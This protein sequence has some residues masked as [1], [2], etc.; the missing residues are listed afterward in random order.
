M[1]QIFGIDPQLPLTYVGI[2]EGAN[3]APS[4]LPYA[5]EIRA[6]ALVAGGRRFSEVLIHQ[7]SG[8]FLRQLEDLGFRDFGPTDVWVLLAL[9]QTIFDVQ[10][11][12]NHA[13]FL[14]R[15]PLPIAGSTR[16][17]SVLLIEGLDDSVMPNHA[18]ESLAWA[19]GP[20]PQLEPVQR[21]LPFVATAASPLSGNIDAETTAALY[22]YVPLGI[23]GMMPTP[24][25]AT[26]LLAILLEGHYCVQSAEE[27][28]RQRIVFFES[29]L[30]D[31][32]PTI[33]DPLS[34]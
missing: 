15:D 18:T 6:A 26:L 17:A 29:A 14:Y 7:R 10:D 4:L 19:L 27:S 30:T 3:H 5:P 24:G 25:C 21:E 33:I 32:A 16:R 23:D 9:L 13:P 22:Q 2:S 1:D 20:I 31:R 12:H 8:A 28:V 11:S 34:D